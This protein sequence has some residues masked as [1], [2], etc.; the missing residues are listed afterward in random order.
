M[1]LDKL[2]LRRAGL[3]G[4]F[5]LAVASASPAH[6]NGETMWVTNVQI[7]GGYEVM[8]W[9]ELISDG[10]RWFATGNWKPLN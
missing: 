7:E 5:A 1:A 6:A 4:L 2:Y 8:V 3:C 9:I 10:F